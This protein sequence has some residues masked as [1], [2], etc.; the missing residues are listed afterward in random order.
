[1]ATPPHQTQELAIPR[2]SPQEP[3][4]GADIKETTA[5]PK[6]NDATLDIEVAEK[7]TP[8]ESDT[9]SCDEEIPRDFWQLVGDYG[10]DSKLTCFCTPTLP[11]LFRLGDKK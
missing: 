3:G 1:M 9:S 5:Y 6:S 4:N 11:V 8:E 10:N 2:A 7:E